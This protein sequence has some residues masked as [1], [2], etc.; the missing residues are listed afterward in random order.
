MVRGRVTFAHHRLRSSVDRKTIDPVLA[1]KRH[2]GGFVSI[3]ETLPSIIIFI[4]FFRNV[5][6]ARRP[7]L[8]W[9]KFFRFSGVDAAVNVSA[10][11]A[12]RNEP[13]HHTFAIYLRSNNPMEQDARCT[14]G[15]KTGVAFASASSA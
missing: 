1:R 8:S 14:H 10:A 3:D 11:E 7:T 15:F 2:T 13:L 9:I 12:D 6:P 5:P 4:F